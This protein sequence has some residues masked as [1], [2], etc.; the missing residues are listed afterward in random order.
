MAK[1]VNKQPLEVGFEHKNFKIMY[2]GIKI[3]LSCTHKPQNKK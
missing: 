2:F 1:V 3:D